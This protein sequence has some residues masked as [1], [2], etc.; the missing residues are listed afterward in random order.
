VQWRVLPATWLLDSV[1]SSLNVDNWYD[2]PLCCPRLPELLWDLY[3]W[4]LRLSGSVGDSVNL[5]ENPW[6]SWEEVAMR[7]ISSTQWRVEEKKELGPVTECHPA[8]YIA[9]YGHPTGSLPFPFVTFVVVVEIRDSEGTLLVLW[10]I[11]ELLLGLVMRDVV[12]TGVGSLVVLF[13]EFFER[14]HRSTELGGRT[15]QVSIRIQTQV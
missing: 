11:F 3:R 1:H 12:V 10:Y 2:I 6:A 7:L 9:L 8:N 15:W 5:L 14:A 4:Y 13:R